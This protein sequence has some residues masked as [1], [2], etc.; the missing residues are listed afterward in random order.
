MCASQSASKSSVC[1]HDQRKLN[2]Y[3]I[4]RAS[5]SL[6]QPAD[7]IFNADQNPMTDLRIDE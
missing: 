3:R 7:Q 4:A 6:Q 1:Q 5:E 2:K